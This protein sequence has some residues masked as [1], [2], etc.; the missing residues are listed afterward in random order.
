VLE[1]LGGRIQVDVEGRPAVELEVGDEGGAK[2]GL[3]KT[4]QYMSAKKIRDAG[5]RKRPREG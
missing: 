5:T 4:N 1:G 2:G 3:E